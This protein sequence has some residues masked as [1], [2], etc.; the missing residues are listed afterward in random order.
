MAKK[1]KTEQDCISGADYLQL[2][3]QNDW[4]Y[5]TNGSYIE[6]ERDGVIVRVP[7]S[8]R[9]LPKE[10]RSTINTALVRAGL[11]LAALVGILAIFVVI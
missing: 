2:A 5:T 4:P 10:T 6:F 3:Q 7:N 8:G 11:V 9:C 1:I